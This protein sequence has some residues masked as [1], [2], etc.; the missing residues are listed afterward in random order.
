MFILWRLNIGEQ[1]PFKTGAQTVLQTVNGLRWAITGDDD[2]FIGIVEAV[3]RVKEL[4]FS[5]FFA[6]DK[7]NIIHKQN[8]DLAVLCT[9]LFGF[10]KANSINDFV[11]E[12]SR[13]D[14]QDS[15]SCC[16]P[17]MSDSV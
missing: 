3:E 14:V 2:L 8:V 11:R 16:L 4:F 15:E 9:E 5:R 17:D 10:L 1:S 7:L 6:G 12:F 13:S